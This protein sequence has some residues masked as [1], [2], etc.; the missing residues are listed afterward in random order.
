MSESTFNL[1]EI[2]NGCQTRLLSCTTSNKSQEPCDFSTNDFYDFNKTIRLIYFF[3]GLLDYSVL[4][5]QLIA[6]NR[7]R[8]FVTYICIFALF[9]CATL[10]RLNLL[11]HSI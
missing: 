7:F 2:I 10:Q 11:H 3:T 5:Y 1:Y 8:L 6:S 9:V 4:A